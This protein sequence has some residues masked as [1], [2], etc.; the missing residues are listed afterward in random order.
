MSKL[1]SK[2]REEL[3]EKIENNKIVAFCVDCEIDRIYKTEELKHRATFQ[4][5]K[6]ENIAIM[7]KYKDSFASERV[8]YLAKKFLR[9]LLFT[10]LSFILIGWFFSFLISLSL[11]LAEGLLHRFFTFTASF[12]SSLLGADYWISAGIYFLIVFI[13]YWRQDETKMLQP[14]LIPE[15]IPPVREQ[16]ENRV[17]DEAER[18]ISEVTKYKK[19]I[20]EEYLLVASDIQEVDQMEGVEFEHFLADIFRRK[21]YNVQLTPASGDDGVDLII[22]K[23]RRKIAV[24]CKRYSG[25]VGVS[26]VQEVFAGKSFYDCDEAMVVTNSTLTAPAVKTARKLGVTL[27]DRSRLIDV[28]A[29]T[30]TSIEW[31][32]YLKRYYA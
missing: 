4:S 14:Q 22:E 21:G 31:D 20:L 9:V 8:K 18:Q 17:L 10:G 6:G 3:F 2:H 13:F 11:A 32:D 12:D 24:Q 29:E 1:C 15:P 27:W 16:I 7:R 5:I 26:A 25:T 19:R 30:Q 28:L 23:A